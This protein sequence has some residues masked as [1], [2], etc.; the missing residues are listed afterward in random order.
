MDVVKAINFAFLIDR[1][2][3]SLFINIANIPIIG[4]IS[5]NDNNIFK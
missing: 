2:S 5:K 4:I 3:L 1:T